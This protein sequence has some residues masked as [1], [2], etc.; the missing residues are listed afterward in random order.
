MIQ[1]EM[2]DSDSEIYV[3]AF[4]LPHKILPIKCVNVELTDTSIKL[5]LNHK[6][7][8]QWRREK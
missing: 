7:L 4:D 5:Y 8:T 6:L 1:K 2:F 3:K